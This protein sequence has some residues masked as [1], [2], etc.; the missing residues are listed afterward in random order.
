M[1]RRKDNKL[2]EHQNPE[3]QNGQK[4]AHS[5]KNL[6]MAIL[7]LIKNLINVIDHII[8]DNDRR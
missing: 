7:T 5:T 4:K 1:L 6:A 3:V 8:G 2:M